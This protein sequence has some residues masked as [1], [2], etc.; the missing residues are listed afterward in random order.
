MTLLSSAECQEFWRNAESVQR[1]CCN[2]L[3][4]DKNKMRVRKRERGVTGVMN[5]EQPTWLGSLVAVQMKGKVACSRFVQVNLLKAFLTDKRYTDRFWRIEMWK[6]SSK[7]KPEIPRLNYSN[8]MLR[9]VKGQTSKS[10]WNVEPLPPLPKSERSMPYSKLAAGPYVILCYIHILIF[11]Q[12]TT[13]LRTW[14]LPFWF[15]GR[16]FVRFYLISRE[17]STII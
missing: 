8:D 5:L 12:S 13:G 4:P 9:P 15:P 11:C 3:G 7:P 14:S 16:N 2:S 10:T 17:Y 1:E 6:N